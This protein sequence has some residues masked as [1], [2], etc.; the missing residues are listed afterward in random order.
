MQEMV[1][2][3]PLQTKNAGPKEMAPIVNM[4]K[5]EQVFIIILS[6]KEAKMALY[7]SMHTLPLEIIG[8]INT[9]YPNIS[10]HKKKADPHHL[11]NG[12]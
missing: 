1:N 5:N 3:H 2:I 8:T 9:T 4:S 12:I 10:N 11:F 7:T 6:I